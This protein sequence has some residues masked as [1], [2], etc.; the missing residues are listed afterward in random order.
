MTTAAMPPLPPPV[1][2][3]I[4]KVRAFI[5]PEAEGGPIV[6]DIRNVLPV[7]NCV[8]FQL[9]SD[10]GPDGWGPGVLGFPSRDGG[11]IQGVPVQIQ[12]LDAAQVTKSYLEATGR[13]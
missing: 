1:Q 9:Q 4:P 12:V 6:V 5:R 2:R 11:G 8:G 10:P 13:G 3:P 7:P